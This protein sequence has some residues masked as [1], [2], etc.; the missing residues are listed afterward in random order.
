MVQNH[1]GDIFKSTLFLSDISFPLS[2]DPAS[3]D[4][5]CYLP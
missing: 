4:K 1:A 5:N 3:F 2:Y